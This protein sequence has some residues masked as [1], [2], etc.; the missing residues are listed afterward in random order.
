MPKVSVVIP[1]YNVE[2]YLREC[3]DSVINQT[4]KDIEIIC[5]DDG[6]TDSSP[7][8][9]DEYASKDKRIK[10]I[11]KENGGY[12]KAMN[13]GLDYA[14]GE[15]IGI[16]EPD[17]YIE[18]NMYEELYEKAVETGVDIV[19]SDFYTF[20]GNDKSRIITY[21]NLDK[22]NSHYNRII[23]PEDDISVFNL[24]VNTW[25]GIYKRD[26]TEKYHIR[27]NE[28][29]G[30]SFQ[31]Q[32]FWFQTFIFTNS[33]YFMKK[34]FYHYRKDNEN[35]SMN[36]KSKIYAIKYEYD[37]IRNILKNNPDKENKFLKIYRRSK[38]SCYVAVLKRSNN[39]LIPEFMKCFHGELEEGVKKNEIDLDL[40]NKRQKY[41]LNLI[42][43][44]DKA[45]L[46]KIYL[47]MSFFDRIFSIKQSIGGK[48][49]IVSILGFKI[50]IKRKKYLV[51]D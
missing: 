4:L 47:Y 5:I 10:V 34:P 37:F 33:V 24:T 11:H 13:I 21:K 23:N 26:F 8:I 36:N 35:S 6:S 19:K 29:P 40:F 42:L 15:Y 7:K 18:N 45:F 32:G 48:F 14:T 17:D 1:I 39:I 2:E 31:D 51:K 22:S 41:L 3:L 9:L 50:K 16:V 49:Y 20:V 38:F 27:H 25:C 30:A 12:G 44:D 28:T 43:N 46:K